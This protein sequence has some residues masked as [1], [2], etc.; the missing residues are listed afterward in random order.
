LKNSW[1]I[2]GNLCFNS[3]HFAIFDVFH[4]TKSAIFDIIA[5][6]HFAIFDIFSQIKSAIFDKSCIFAAN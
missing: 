5:K 1:Q 4:E 2:G 3:E 6:K